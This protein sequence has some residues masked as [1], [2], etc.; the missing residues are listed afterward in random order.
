MAAIIGAIA[1]LTDE[2]MEHNAAIETVLT[3]VEEP[4]RP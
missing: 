3:I 1:R 2:G 4:I